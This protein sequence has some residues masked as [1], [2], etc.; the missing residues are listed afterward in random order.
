MCIRDSSKSYN[1]SAPLPSRRLLC[2]LQTPEYIYWRSI[3]HQCRL[4][5]LPC[6][7][8]SQM[9]TPWARLLNIYEICSVFTPTWAVVFAKKSK[10]GNHRAENG[11]TLDE[12]QKKREHTLNDFEPGRLIG[13]SWGGG[14]DSSYQHF[15]LL[16]SFCVTIWVKVAKKYMPQMTIAENRVWTL[17]ENGKMRSNSKNHLLKWLERKLGFLDF[18]HGRCLD[19]LFRKPSTASR[20][21]F[22]SG[23]TRA[24]DV[25]ADLRRIECWTI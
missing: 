1:L 17:A 8:T 24:H 2:Y 11:C 6:W 5:L 10:T 19:N 15:S 9:K 18:W 4:P 14:V 25:H 16:I 13:V 22:L 23:D 3:V 21:F 20:H 12:K 7:K